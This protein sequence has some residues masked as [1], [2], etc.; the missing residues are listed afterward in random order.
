M[1][2]KRVLVTDD[3]GVK[4]AIVQPPRAVRAI[5]LSDN[6]GVR[7]A[8]AELP[9]P[10]QAILVGE[11]IIQFNGGSGGVTDGNKGDI[12][13]SGSGANWIVNALS[14]TLA[15]IA[16]AAYSALN[17]ANTLVQRNANGSFAVTNIDFATLSIPNVARM[18][19]ARLTTSSTSSDQLVDSFDTTQFRSAKYFVQIESG[20]DTHVSELLVSNN[21]L[22]PPP[23]TQYANIKSGG[24]LAS[25]RFELNGSNIRLLVTPAN[26]ITKIKVFRIT[27]E[28]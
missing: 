15:K 8:I 18:T 4:L 25:L 16:A 10:V 7:L 6:S 19:G 9:S 1:T 21:G 3:L 28:A 17:L 22:D 23:F 27:I 24:D 14:I 12:T 11:A 20:T 13:V 2:I 5:A 26:S